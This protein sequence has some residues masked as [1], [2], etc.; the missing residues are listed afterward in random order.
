[1]T[2]LKHMARE[3]ISEHFWIRGSSEF[4]SNKQKAAL[5]KKAFLAGA[6]AGF[7]AARTYDHSGFFPTK[8]VRWGTFNDWAKD[9]GEQ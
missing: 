8:F 6:E 5:A 7:A 2:T 3:W 9:G 4:Q 1:M